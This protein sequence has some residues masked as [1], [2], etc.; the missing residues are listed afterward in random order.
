M[1]WRI[2]DSAMLV[3]VAGTGLERKQMASKSFREAFC[4][5]EPL[6]GFQLTSVGP[7]WARMLRG[8]VD[9]A[10][11]D[12]EHHCF[13]REQV[14]WTSAVYAGHDIT[15]VVRVLQPDAGLVRAAFD[16]GAQAVVVPYVE[17]VEQAREVVAAAKLRPIQGLR[18]QSAMSDDPLDET[19]L[20][21][22]RQHTGDVAVLIQIESQTAV[23]HLDTL[24]SVPG[25]DGVLVGPYD[26]TASLG[27]LG[28]HY[29]PGF[30]TAAQRIAAKT[31]E[32][33]LGA[34][35]YFAESPEKEAMARQWGY[36]LMIAGCDWSLI[37][38]SLN[39]RSSIAAD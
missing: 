9:F 7:H 31:R 8:V 37:R 17:T 32:K 6:V 13:S 16:D 30:Q 39:R 12:C 1:I 18:A 24:L 3:E 20:A 15:P 5:G 4:G 36:N 29:A 22:S 2:H 19:T 21:M 11:I 34:G 38:E 28:D 10:F 33:G 14:A 23:D 25:L 26:L 27:C 35:I